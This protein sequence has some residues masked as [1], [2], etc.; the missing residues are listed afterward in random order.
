MKRFVDDN[1]VFEIKIPISWKYSL[2]DNRVHT[3]EEYDPWNSDCFQF[4][5]TKI[6]SEQRKKEL[7]QMF[8][9]LPPLE[10]SDVDYRAYP[11]NEEDSL[12]IK[13]WT[14]I[15][16]NEVIHFTLIVDKDADPELNPVPVEEKVKTVHKILASFDLI[17]DEYKERK[18][19]SY[20]F[21]MFLQG[22]GATNLMLSKAIESKAFIEA[23]CLLGTQI[24]SL[25]RIAIVLKKQLI[26]RNM[27]I[28]KEWI[29][30]GATDKK[31]S[32]KDIYKKAKELG[33]LD[34]AT[35]DNLYK[36]YE[37]RNRVV[38]RFIISEITLADVESISYEYYQIREKIKQAVDDI[39]SEQIKQNIGMTTVDE[40]DPGNK[41]PY[42]HFFMGKIG[43]V[44][45]F[46][47]NQ[48]DSQAEE[49]V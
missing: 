46:D 4:S 45:Y 41:S 8:S 21:E 29:Y 2:L 1:A 47:E 15:F 48:K 28:E 20:R 40:S 36:L 44:Q 7:V 42:M 38:H 14:T 16:G 32:E 19:N 10:I 26:N 13:S 9:L 30:Q 11:D 23:T 37:D 31:K 22:I 49:Q 5:I 33:I 27:V 12:I 3:F 34:E 18:L 6:E 39:E 25:L 43:K 35:F 24:D 17:P